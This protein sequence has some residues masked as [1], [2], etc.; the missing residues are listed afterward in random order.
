MSAEAHG[1]SDGRQTGSVAVEI[2]RIRNQG[3]DSFTVSYFADGKR[4][5]K[6]FACFVEAHHG[7]SPPDLGQGREV[8]EFM[9]Q[10]AMMACSHRYVGPRYFR[11]LPQSCRRK[12]GRAGLVAGILPRN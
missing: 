6:M 7:P 5:L 8:K 4:Q 9:K 10:M 1:L 11:F 2:P 12:F 3:R